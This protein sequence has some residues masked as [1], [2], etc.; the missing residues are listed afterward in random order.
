MQNTITFPG[1]GLSFYIDRVAFSIGGLH[2]YWYGIII[3]VGFLLGVLY[4]L[5]RCKNVGLKTDDFI[6]LLLFAVPF[7]II[8]ARAYYVVWKYN[9][10]Y[11]YDT[12]AMFRIWDGGIAIYGAIIAGVITAVIFC[13]VRRIRIG[14][15]LDV[16]AMGLLIGQAIG[17]WGNF[18]NQEAYGQVTD[19]F[20]RMGI[21]V[22]GTL[23][24]VQPTF[25]YESLWNAAGLLIL[26]FLFT[27]R[28]RSGEIFLLY[29]AWYGIGRGIIEGMRS[30]SLY[31]FNSSL[32]I[33]QFVGFF[34]AI[35]AVGILIYLF[36]FVEYDA[37][38]LANPYMPKH[39]RKKIDEEEAA[40]E[41]EAEEEAPE[42]VVISGI[43]FNQEKDTEKTEE[44]L[45][46][47]AQKPA[48]DAQK[49]AQDAQKP[50]E[51]AE[52]PADGED[53]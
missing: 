11:Y 2:V 22:N 39:A 10:L 12:M 1:L 6:D 43:A 23:T 33:S 28:K 5:K 35:V 36:L 51:K 25:L 19:S 18:V 40:Q 34:S 8:G 29:T 20:L 3:A 44:K 32:R 48:Q 14:A 24:Y 30:D 7:A 26:H 16:A 53:K 42:A 47:D 17:R 52:K 21:Y 4:C 38:I 49:P 41:A 46:Q 15:V 45:A 31:F 27:H 37:E 50:D 13:K 9:E